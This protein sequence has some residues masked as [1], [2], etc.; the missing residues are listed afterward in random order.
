[1]VNIY[2]GYEFVNDFDL[3]TG[4]LRLTTG[5]RILPLGVWYTTVILSKGN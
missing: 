1:M 5:P 3:L 4:L 2:L